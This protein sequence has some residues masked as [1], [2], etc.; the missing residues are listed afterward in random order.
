MGRFMLADSSFS[1]LHSSFNVVEGREG[2]RE[3]YVSPVDRLMPARNAETIYRVERLA[4]SYLSSRYL[5]GDR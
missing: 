5:S 2:G 1:L 4:R 3:S